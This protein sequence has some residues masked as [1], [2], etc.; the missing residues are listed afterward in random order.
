MPRIIRFV[1]SIL[2]KIPTAYIFSSYRTKE[3]YQ[4]CIRKK[5]KH[6]I[7]LPAPVDTRAY[8]QITTTNL[9]SLKNRFGGRLIVGTLANINPIKGIEAIIE[10]AVILKKYEAEVEFIVCG[11]VHQNQT[12]YYEKLISKSQQNGVIN[13]S[14]IGFTDAPDLFLSE[15]DIYLCSSLA[16]S[17]PT[18]VWEAMASATP[19]VS[20]DVGDVLYQFKNANAGYVVPL[21]DL[22]GLARGVECYIKSPE[23]R[24]SDGKNLQASSTSELDIEVIGAA[25]RGFCRE[26]LRT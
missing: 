26:I 1:F 23:L 10:V 19:V 21:G 2:S 12:R 24:K 13:V 15:V 11:A 16:E 20:F 3:Y 8:E 7:I 5:P 17:S 22:D 18:A 6:E 9:K 25:Y 4:P 14:F